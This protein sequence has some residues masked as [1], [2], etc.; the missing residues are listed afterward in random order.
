MSVKLLNHDAKQF[1]QQRIIEWRDRAIAYSFEG[2]GKGYDIKRDFL[3]KLISETEG[4]LMKAELWQ[5]TNDDPTPVVGRPE[6]IKEI[7]KKEIRGVVILCCNAFFEVKGLYSEEE[8]KL[9]VREKIRKSKSEVDY[10]KFRQETP[11]ADLEYERLPIPE[12]VRNE[13]WRR[14]QGKCTQC[15]SVRN[16]EFDH[17]VPVS[18][19]GSN[20]ARNIQ[21][22]CETCNRRKSD[23]IG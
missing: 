2:R 8:A 11:E 23:G 21:L 4:M 17:I 20:T 15:Q 5:K 16:L 3:A 10:L 22:L 6:T 18:K 14:D 12:A 7:F 9:L 19:G 1:L 13:V